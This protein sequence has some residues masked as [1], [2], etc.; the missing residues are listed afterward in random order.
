MS[1]PSTALAVS[2]LAQR[3]TV[4]SP[5]TSFAISGRSLPTSV[6]GAESG[7]NSRFLGTEPSDYFIA[8]LSRVDVHERARGGV[9]VFF[10]LDARKVVRK[11]L[12]HHQ[13]IGRVVESARF[14]VG[15]QLVNRVERMILN[16]RFGV[17]FARG[18]QG[19]H[20]FRR[21]FAAFVAVSVARL[22][23]LVAAHKHVVHAP[24]VDS[25]RFDLSEFPERFLNSRRHFAVK[26]VEIPVKVDRFP[27]RRTRRNGELRSF[28][29]FRRPS[30]RR[31]AARS[32]LRD[33]LQESSNF[34]LRSVCVLLG[35]RNRFAP[36]FSS[37]NHIIPP[38]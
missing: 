26:N 37:F 15:I 1:T 17:N 38:F 7:V 14:K 23:N 4:R 20:F 24:G 35:R 11:V 29:V 32:T 5:P 28:R 31:C 22:Y 16:T 33:R 19:F 10:F 21:F 34:F 12:G 25:E 30:N 36:S 3:T 6:P 27:S 13:K 9:G 2:W 8:V 18:K